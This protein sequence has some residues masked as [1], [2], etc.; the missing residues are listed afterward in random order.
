MEQQEAIYYYYLISCRDDLVKHTYIG[1]TQNFELRKRQHKYYCNNANYP[2]HN[3]KLYRT[4][5]KYGG[6]LNFKIELIYEVHGISK[7]EA[8]EFERAVYDEYRPSLNNNIPNRTQKEYIKDNF[9]QIL[10]KRQN[11]ETCFW[12]NRLVSAH[13]MKR[14]RETNIKCLRQQTKKMRND[15]LEKLKN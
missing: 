4:I 1:K 10:I 6:M 8:C 5:R 7:Q 13:N 15:I 2:Q 9:K 12:C 14:H 3:Y 11:K